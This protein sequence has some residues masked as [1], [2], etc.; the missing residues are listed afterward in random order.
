MGFGIGFHI[1]PFFWSS[2]GGGRRKKGEWYGWKYMK[3]AGDEWEKNFKAKPLTERETVIANRLT[4]AVDNIK[5]QQ[6]SVQSLKKANSI[7]SKAQM[8]HPLACS[9]IMIYG[10]TVKEWS[11]VIIDGYSRV[12]KAQ[13][14]KKS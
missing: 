6:A 13:S 4:M 2:G 3:E 8:G 5:Q 7:F 9:K 14:K 10:H 12:A 1:G 11:D